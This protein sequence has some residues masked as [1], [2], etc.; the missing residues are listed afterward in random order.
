MLPIHPGGGGGGGGGGEG[1]GGGGGGGGKAEEEEGRLPGQAPL[2][3]TLANGSKSCRGSESTRQTI[4]LKYL[5]IAWQRQ[6]S[7]QPQFEPERATAS[8]KRLDY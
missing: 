7:T 4:T 2:S 3:R 8:A 1:G 6:I 5:P